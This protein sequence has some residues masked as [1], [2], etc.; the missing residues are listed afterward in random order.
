[1]TFPKYRNSAFVRTYSRLHC[2]LAGL[3]F[4]LF[5]SATAVAAPDSECVV[6]LHGLARTSS[7]MDTLAN[8]L[9]ATGYAVANVD[10]PSRQKPIEELAGPAVADGLAGCPHAVTKVHFVTHSLGG[11]LVR[12]HLAQ[13]PMANLGRVVML[14]P[15][16]KG[17][18][19]VDSLRD[20]P[21]YTWLNG[22]AGLQLGTEPTS[23]VNT[24]GPVDFPLGV[25]AGTSTFNPLLSLTLPNPDDGKVSVEHTK[26]DGMADLIEMPHTHTFM[27]SA[28][29]VIAQV[30][31]FL[32]N[33]QFR[34]DSP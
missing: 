32:Q 17:S 26:V 10:Y 2:V 5:A 12:Y 1:M 7:S 19:V 11:I 20:V 18:H 8:S 15:P 22:P 24:L 30:K 28:K 27:M 33:G 6:L 4:S 29:P 3:L 16:N 14:G 25:I 21:G 34:R 23:V 13:K 31:Y 9:R